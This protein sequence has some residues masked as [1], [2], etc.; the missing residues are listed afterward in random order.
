MCPS[1]RAEVYGEM[2]NIFSQNSSNASKLLLSPSI[3]QLGSTIKDKQR[4]SNGFTGH[5]IPPLS[6][7]GSLSL[8]ALT[9]LLTS[10]LLS[11]T[12]YH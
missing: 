5:Q 2:L 11:V 4:M 7:F 12:L 8:A 1:V 6:G 10:F 3:A 9:F